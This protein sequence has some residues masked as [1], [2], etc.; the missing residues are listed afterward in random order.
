MR[1]I[2]LPFCLLLCG[3]LL[4]ACDEEGQLAS[5]HYVEIERGRPTPPEYRQDVA[6]CFYAAASNQMSE[7][8]YTVFAAYLA[9]VA[10]RDDKNNLRNLPIATRVRYMAYGQIAMD[11]Y[12]GCRAERV[13]KDALT[14]FCKGKDGCI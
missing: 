9:E 7:E 10:K 12:L 4:A 8:G 11:L 5:R 14:Q 13:P 2:G 6:D 1:F 3:P